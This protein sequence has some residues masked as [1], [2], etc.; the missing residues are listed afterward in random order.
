MQTRV[1]YPASGIGYGFNVAYNNSLPG[2]DYYVQE[3]ST[4]GVALPVLVTETGWASHR[5]GL[6]QCSEDDKAQ[7]YVDAYTDVWLKDSRV[8]GVMP[9]MLQD[10]TW[11]DQDGYAFVLMNGQRQPCFRAVKGLRCSLDIG[12]GCP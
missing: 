10:Q 4:I 11:G 6:P 8:L 7:W 9:F 2:L 5:D 1:R 12:G 3:L